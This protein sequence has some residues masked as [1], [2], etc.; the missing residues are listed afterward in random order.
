MDQ[1]HA[2]G[3][4]AAL[5]H[6]GLSDTAAVHLHLGGVGTHLALEEGLLHLRNELGCSDDHAT[7]GDELVDVCKKERPA[8]PLAT[9]LSSISCGVSPGWIP[10]QTGLS[11]LSTKD[12]CLE[13]Q[14]DLVMAGVAGRHCGQDTDI[15]LTTVRSGLECPSCV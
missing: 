7:D 14:R 15:S 1:R 2:V 8:C 11:L 10:A 13:V 6:T 9:A 12:S 3:G 5:A 4:V